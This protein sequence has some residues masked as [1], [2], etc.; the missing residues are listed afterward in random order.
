[1]NLS[2]IL[3]FFSKIIKDWIEYSYLKDEIRQLLEDVKN[4]R[5]IY[6]E[7]INALNINNIKLDFISYYNLEKIVTNLNEISCLV[8]E[9]NLKSNL[10]LIFRKNFMINFNRFCD[11][12]RSH[13][14]K[15]KEI[16]DKILKNKENKNIIMVEEIEIRIKYL[17]KVKEKAEEIIKIGKKLV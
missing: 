10:I 12:I 1:M 16:K 5:V 3:K 2:K 13:N 17:E 6:K 7:F 9:K 8:C 14:L 4:Q 15:I 11:L